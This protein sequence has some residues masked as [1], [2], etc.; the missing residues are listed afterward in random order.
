M[1]FAMHAGIACLVLHLHAGI[2]CVVLHLHA[3]IVCQASLACDWLFLVGAQTR[4]S[5]VSFAMICGYLSFVPQ[6]EFNP[7][8]SNI[9]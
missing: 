6:W 5:V 2:A 1:T 7:I 9:A 3:G 4:V 8:S